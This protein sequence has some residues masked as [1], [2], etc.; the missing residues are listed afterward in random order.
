[1][2]KPIFIIIGFTIGNIVAS[3]IIGKR[4]LEDVFRI[5]CY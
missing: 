3:I 1:M 4:D 5:S 2:L